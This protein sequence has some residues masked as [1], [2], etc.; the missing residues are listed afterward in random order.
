MSNLLQSIKNLREL[1][2]RPPPQSFSLPNI[3]K[4]R[5]ELEKIVDEPSEVSA[6]ELKAL[7]EKWLDGDRDFSRRE[8]KN[9]PFIIYDNRLPIDDLTEILRRMDFSRETHLKNL[10]AAYLSNYDGSEKTVR[11]RRRL[12]LAFV[13]KPLDC[14]YR[15]KM[16]AQIYSDGQFLFDEN[17][18]E[19][20]SSRF[21]N[22]SSIDDVLSSIGLPKFFKGSNFIRRALKNFLC[23]SA[24]DIKRRLII[25]YDLSSDANNYDEIIQAAANVIIPDVE[26][27][28]EP[29]DKKKCLEIFY[30]ELG[31]PRFGGLTYRW[32]NVSARAR[33]IFL[34][35]IAASDL[36]LFFKIIDQAAVDRM[37]RYRKSF[38]TAYLPYIKNT[39]VFLG[40]DA[41]FFARRLNDKI[42]HHGKLAG[43]GSDQSVLAFQIGN[44]VF[45][46]W[47]HNGKLRAYYYDGDA[48][49]W[50]GAR[51]IRRNDII[52][53]FVV[54]EWVHSNPTG[55]SWQ[56]NVSWW[57]ERFCGIDR[58]IWW[59]SK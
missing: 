33:E 51:E 43:G 48:K 31:D 5:A 2:L 16:L 57:L 19:S 30:R 6:V 20:M 54:E 53:S 37:W 15:S 9:L 13:E 39:W 40:R 56:R 10:I 11:L 38:W 45:V 24:I 50:F 4:L 49:D 17:C 28:S 36:D 42:L 22:A 12:G 32:D 27:M 52:Y 55:G 25:F 59:E 3:E 34:H 26:S 46:E 41:Q 29:V 23:A 47:S 14:K 18:I 21:I 35:W 58:N 7:L 44:Y 8:I 1:N